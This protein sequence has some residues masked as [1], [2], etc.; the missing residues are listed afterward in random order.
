MSVNGRS[1]DAIPAE[2]RKNGYWRVVFQNSEDQEV[3]LVQ[4][5]EQNGTAYEPRVNRI[6]DQKIWGVGDFVFVSLIQSFDEI[7]GHDLA[8]RQKRQR[9]ILFAPAANFIKQFTNCE[10]SLDPYRDYRKWCADLNK[11]SVLDGGP[12][13]VTGSDLVD[14]VSW[15][16]L[17]FNHGITAQQAYDE[18]K[19]LI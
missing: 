9:A 16:R 8:E 17:V 13:L 4:G 3:V 15:S 5:S 18:I 1:W 6:G 19:S 2:Q 14:K 7:Q 11:I 10:R 12:Q